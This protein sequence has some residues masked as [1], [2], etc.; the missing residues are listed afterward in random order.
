MGLLKPLRQ[1]SG[2]NLSAVF[3]HLGRDRRVL[4]VRRLSFIDTRA[5]VDGTSF[6]FPVR[7]RHVLRRSAGGRDYQLPP[8]RQ[9]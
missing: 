5:R 7:A 3:R 6:R 2:N 8:R 9:N 1:Y 4:L